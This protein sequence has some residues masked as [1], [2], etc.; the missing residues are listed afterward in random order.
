MTRLAIAFI[1]LLIAGPAR[2]LDPE[3][4][5][6]TL[7][8]SETEAAGQ[9]RLPTAPWTPDAQPAIEIGAIQR[10]VFQVPASTRTPVQLLSNLRQTLAEDGYDEVFSCADMACGGFDFRFQLDIIGEPDMH[11]DLGNYLYV[12]MQ[13]PDSRTDPRLVALVASRT[14]TTGFVHITTV[15]KPEPVIDSPA[16]SPPAASP[17]PGNL[18]GALEILGKAVIDGLDFAT[19]SAELG[20]GPYPSLESLADWLR[21]NPTA[22]V[23][24]VGHTDSIGSLEGNTALSRQ[25][26]AAVARFLT[27]SL[28]VDPAQ[29]Q[30]SG[31]GYLAPLASNLTEAGRALNRRVEVVLLSRDE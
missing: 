2:A 30:S 5:N 11:V 7:V 28:G 22:R 6:A 29:I 13:A 3:L 1:C 8:R 25:R 17:P 31:V 14:R 20:A 24:L 18:T 16:P 15:S 12:L 23:V 4:P 21:E 10:D 9:V 26:A 27:G 19:G